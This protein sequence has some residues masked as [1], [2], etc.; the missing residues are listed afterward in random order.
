MIQWIILNL[1]TYI[2][3]FVNWNYFFMRKWKG[4][5]VRLIHELPWFTKVLYLVNMASRLTQIVKAVSGVIDY[6]TTRWYKTVMVLVVFFRFNLPVRILLSKDIKVDVKALKVSAIPP[7][8]E[9]PEW[10]VWL[11]LYY[12]CN[13]AS[14]SGWRKLSTKIISL[15][16][17]LNRARSR[18]RASN[19]RPAVI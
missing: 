13:T 4:G 19:G 16:A 1:N 3:K 9:K 18:V 15:F 14:M 11:N 8:G 17:S 10:Q 7:P 6:I 5:I 12:G 2:F